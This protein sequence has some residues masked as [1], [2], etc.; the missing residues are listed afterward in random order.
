MHR[1]SIPVLLALLSEQLAAQAGASFPTV[2]PP[3]GEWVNYFTPSGGFT[4]MWQRIGVR[5]CNTTAAVRQQTAADFSRAAA[6]SGIRLATNAELLR[7]GAKAD[8][9]SWQRGV[10]LAVELA[11]WTTSALMASDLIKIKEAYKPA[12]PLFSGAL[13]LTTTLVK[14]PKFELPSDPRPAIVQLD[15]GAC[16]DFT[17]FG[18]TSNV[19]H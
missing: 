19:I 14:A 11:G 16:G 7:A 12:I 6:Q 9:M 15:A 3:P 1:S 5:I 8:S 10:L 17:V 2:A 4:G 13:R 18:T